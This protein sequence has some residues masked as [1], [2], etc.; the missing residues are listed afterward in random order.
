MEAAGL[1][2]LAAFNLLVRKAFTEAV[3]RLEVCEP[4]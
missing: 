4:P 2:G 1:G 3:N